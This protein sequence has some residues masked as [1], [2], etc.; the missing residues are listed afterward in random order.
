MFRE[1]SNLAMKPSDVLAPA[2][3]ARV[4]PGM[5]FVKPPMTK[6]EAEAAA[7]LMAMENACVTPKPFKYVCAR[8]DWPLG[9]IFAAKAAYWPVKVTMG[10]GAA[11][12]A[13]LV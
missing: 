5:P 3:T 7:G 4:L 12:K 1:R 10:A 13:R 6:G 9:A 11:A 2:P 8:R